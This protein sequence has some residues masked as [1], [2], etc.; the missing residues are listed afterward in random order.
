MSVHSTWLA[1]AGVSMLSVLAACDQMTPAP[2]KPLTEQEKS[3]LSMAD[4]MQ[5]GGNYDGA[6][7]IYRELIAK[8]FSST[9]PS[10]R[11]SSIY[12]A[13]GKAQ[14]SVALMREAEKKAPA[15]EAVLLELGYALIADNQP[16]EAVNVF[17]KLTAINH[18]SASA[19][20]GKAVAFDHA[21]NHVAAQEI[22]QKALKLAPTSTTI[23]NNLALSMI[24]ND[25]VDTA[26][27]LLEPISHRP[28]APAAIRH[29]LALAY[30]V[31]G[32]MAR[33]RA[34]NLKDMTPAQA[35]ENEKFYAYYTQMLKKQ[36][37]DAVAGTLKL[38]L[39]DASDMTEPIELTKAPETKAKPAKKAP[40]AK[41]ETP[42]AKAK[43]AAKV[44]VTE[45]Y[46]EEETPP[47]PAESVKEPVASDGKFMGYDA[48]PTYPST[49]R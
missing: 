32:D 2:D 18:D 36:K 13:N 26:I 16:E 43:A 20:N 21:G 31:K 49:R 46:P 17:D 24:L 10:V 3:A 29:N 11:L 14:E 19:Y 42:K 6:A 4:S 9:V 41:S 5:K 38:D 48:T 45:V 33:A 15:D 44:P 22:Y 47:A 23:Q 25:Q 40:A 37:I 39:N 8:Q 27:S 1:L 7:D 12:R 34:I 30:G 28:N 35:E